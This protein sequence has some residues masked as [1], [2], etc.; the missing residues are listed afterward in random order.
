[1]EVDSAENEWGGA[2]EDEVTQNSAVWEDGK[3]LDM[4]D[5]DCER[6]E[7]LD[8]MANLEKK[9]ASLKGCLYKEW[10]RQ[11][12][13]K[14]QDILSGKA[15]EYLES[16]ARLPE[17]MQLPTESA[18]IS[19][20]LCLAQTWT[21]NLLHDTVQSELEKIR[22]EEG[23]HSCDITSRSCNAELQSWQKSS[24][25]FRGMHS[26]HT[27]I[28]IFL[29]TGQWL[30]ESHYTESTPNEN[31]TVPEAWKN[32]CPVPD[33]KKEGCISVVQMWTNNTCW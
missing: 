24:C 29:E 11:V 5:E 27:E 9:F 22:L 15:P 26:V 30:V 33:L 20:E 13:I 14:I 4:V 8:E 10:V 23:R 21:W 16:L 3:R 1:M 25:C 17:N 12:D 19:R 32:I 6:M 2:S 18:E 31:R 7:C 28:L